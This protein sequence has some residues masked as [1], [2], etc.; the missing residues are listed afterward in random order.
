MPRT[1]TYSKPETYSKPWYIQNPGVLETLAYSTPKA[2]SDIYDYLLLLISSILIQEKG[3]TESL[4]NIGNGECR[5][6]IGLFT[7]FKNKFQ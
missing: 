1:L 3:F 2:Y 5:P 7:P 4:L 6:R